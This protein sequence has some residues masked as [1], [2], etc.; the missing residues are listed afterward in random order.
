MSNPKIVR[1]QSSSNLVWLDLEMTGLD[2]QYD[3]IL[4]AALIVTD[5]DLQPLESHACVIWQPDHELQKMTP[6]V[7]EMHT[8]TGLIERVRASTLDLPSAEKQIL[9]RI[10][11]WCS[12]GVTL[13]GNSVGHDKRFIDRYMPALAG[14]LG[15][16]IV[17]VSSIKM[18]ARL[19]YGEGAV[20]QKPAEGAHDAVVD[21][22]RSIEELRH[23]RATLFRG[24]S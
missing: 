3:V 7:R 12:F 11:G 5:K 14:Y 20:Y 19:W 6:F 8:K 15:Y 24:V 22:Q 9:E 16:R 10:S 17:D 23:Y 18:L 2:A 13:C 21:I 1:T 4:Q